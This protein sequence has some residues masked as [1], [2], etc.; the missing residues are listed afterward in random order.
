M[1]K[2]II[3]NINGIIFNID[4]DAFDKL[5]VY[6]DELKR[7]FITIEEGKE[8]IEDIEA[9]IAELMQPRIS[10]TR[11]SINLEDILEIIGLLG[12]PQDIA[13]TADE[14]FE[15][16]LE[17]TETKSSRKINRRLYRH[18]D[19]AILGGVCSGLAAYFNIDPVIVRILFVV[20]SFAWAIALIIYPIL[21][22]AIPVATTAAQKLEMRGESVTISNL[23]RT[24]RDEYTQVKQNIQRLNANSLGSKIHAFFQELIHLIGKLIVGVWTI[25]KYLLG[26]FM[27]LFSI[28]FI[29]GLISTVYFNTN[30]VFM[31]YHFLQNFSSLKE[32]LYFII[33]PFMADL[34]LIVGVFILLMP[35]SALIYGGLKLILR[36]QNRDKWVILSLTIVWILAIITFANNLWSIYGPFLELLDIFQKQANLY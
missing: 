24:L 35:L 12:E 1:K 4:E 29:I 36:F 32:Y 15:P 8:I 34:L 2:T 10:E 14:G 23:E 17:P 22:I 27:I 25:F 3:I 13:G 20:F 26:S 30:T 21:W 11:Q 6:L 31:H 9:R 19:H 28:A 5:Q 16:P 7:Y 18:P 33:N